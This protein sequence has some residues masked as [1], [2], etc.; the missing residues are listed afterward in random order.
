MGTVR[1]SSKMGGGA[2]A[3]IHFIYKFR[4]QPFKTNLIDLP[5]MDWIEE[6]DFNFILRF[7]NINI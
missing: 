2:V 1:I 5:R 6:Y 4:F 7:F 3:E